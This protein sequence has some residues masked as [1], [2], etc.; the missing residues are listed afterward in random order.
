MDL[1]QAITQGER[2]DG[3]NVQAAGVIAERCGEKPKPAFV[4]ESVLVQKV[5]NFSD[6]ADE[7]DALALI[8][9]KC[10]A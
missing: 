7:I 6:E 4:N 1:S 8:G 3:V 2:R 5:K 9:Q 10:V